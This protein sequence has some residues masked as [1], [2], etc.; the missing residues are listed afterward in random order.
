MYEFYIKD[1]ST[2]KVEF[3]KSFDSIDDVHIVD[4]DKKIFEIKGKHWEFL[5]SQ[6]TMTEFEGHGYTIK[7]LVREITTPSSIL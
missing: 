2:N 7:I 3:L 5:K 4:K 1:V 6:H